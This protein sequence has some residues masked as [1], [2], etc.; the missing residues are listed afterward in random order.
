MRRI[1]FR[2]I[3]PVIFGFL[4]VALFYWDYENS[5][6]V[7]EMG[8][9]WDTGPPIWP[10]RAVSLFL[11]A[12]NA[13]AYLISW[14]I[15]RLL[16]LHTDW[17]QDA[18]WF[19]ALIALWWWVGS[20]IDFGPLG[21]RSYSRRRLVAG[22]LVVVS[23]V[24]LAVATIVGFDEYRWARDYWRGN[25]PIYAVLLL[26]AI[27]P[28]IWCLSF[29]A[30]FVRAAIHLVRNESPPSILNPY[31]YRAFLM[32][33]ALL[34]LNATGIA[35]LDRFI[36]PIVD[37]N[38][39]VIDRLYRLGCVH[40]T[41]TDENEKPIGRIEVNLIPTF[42]VGNARW[43]GTK[44][45][46]TDEQGRYNFN[47]MESGKY[48]L[49]VN[50]FEASPGPD[51]ERPFATRYYRGAGDELAAESVIVRQPFA[52]NLDTLRLPRLKGATTIG[53]RVVWEDGTRPERSN[54]ALHN[55]RYSEM[56]SPL[57]QV[58]NG[59][60]RVDLLEGFEYEV[61]ASVECDG[62][63][64]IEQRESKPVQRINTAVGSAPKEV[65]FVLPGPRCVLWESR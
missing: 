1:R 14:P 31:G 35:Y 23:V 22:I 49:A 47:R 25:P 26:R 13:P 43:Y 64:V 18:V 65:T 37:P 63:K 15:L 50:S 11:Y 51:E 46:W 28:M 9:G 7:A 33:T 17:L 10:Y 54:I 6:V 38:S 61:N 59:A 40:G 21:R 12:V 52:T 60:G 56:H 62:G 8:M 3:L 19:P 55:T 57:K 27:G 16:K 44:S 30:I 32:G 39:C 24:L 41:V 20:C 36:N 48:I 4:A 45:E 58:D 29:V 53:V 42:E 5:R 34:C 2:I